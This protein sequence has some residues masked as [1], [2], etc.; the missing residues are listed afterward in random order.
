[1][2]WKFLK[3]LPPPFLAEFPSIFS[4]SDILEDIE[5][6]L[7]I[8]EPDECGKVPCENIMAMSKGH[9][10]VAG[11]LMAA[12]IVQGGPAPDFLASWVYDYTSSGI[13]SV[14]IDPKKL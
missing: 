5:L 14:M 6:H 9:F 8:N 3:L 12:S 11:E 1:M 7:F 13:E 10:H 4:F 2:C